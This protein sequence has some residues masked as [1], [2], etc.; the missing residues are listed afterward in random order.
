MDL[1]ELAITPT[2]VR[3]PVFNGHVESVIA[4]FD[5]PISLTEAREALKTGRGSSF[6][7]KSKNDVYPT[8]LEVNGSDATCVGGSVR[9]SASTMAWHSGASQTTT[10]GAASNAVQIAEV[11]VRDHL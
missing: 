3:V 8:Q 4:E 11:L 1:P 2:C 9:H 10:K 6:K 5:A 7:M